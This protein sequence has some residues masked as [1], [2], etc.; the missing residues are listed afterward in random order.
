MIG[1]HLYSIFDAYGIWVNNQGHSVEYRPVLGALLRSF[2]PG[3]GQIYNQEYGK[4]GLLYMG[5]LGASVSMFSRQDVIEYY[6]DR[7]HALEKEDPSSESLDR[8]NEQILYYRKNRNQYIWGL[9]LIYLYS[10]GDAVVDAMMSDFD[11]PAH[12]VLGPDFRGG[13]EA[14]ITLDF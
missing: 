9:V 2:V 7:K 6:L 5:L 3:W 4:A 11:S 14:S 1:V 12:F 10:I 8:I 13:L